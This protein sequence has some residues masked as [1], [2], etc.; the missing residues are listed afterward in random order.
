MVLEC[1]IQPLWS[2]ILSGSAGELAF[3]QG[4]ECR[5]LIV[6]AKLNLDKGHAKNPK[7]KNSFTDGLR[8]CVA[9]F[10]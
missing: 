3:Q 4:P 1:G 10:R 2:V 9:A 6:S 8:R 7:T 5:R